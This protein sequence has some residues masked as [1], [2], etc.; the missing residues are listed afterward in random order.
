MFPVV[1]LSVAAALAVAFAVRELLRQ[2]V[3]DDDPLA[4]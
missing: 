1:I 3:E 4:P 2:E